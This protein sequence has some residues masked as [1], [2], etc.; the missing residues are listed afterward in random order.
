[1]ISDLAALVSGG[2]KM[3]HDDL[4]LNV[5]PGTAESVC[6]QCLKRIP[7]SKI[8]VGEKVYLE[9][10]CP[11]HGE[12][13]CL[14]WN[15]PP[16][17]EAWARKGEPVFP[18]KPGTPANQGCP[19]DCGLC[20]EHRQRTCCVLL[21]ITQRCDL[22]CPVCFA[23][24]E[25][26]AEA[27]PSLET[28]AGWYDFLLEQ[29]GPFNIQLSGGE[30][31]QRDDLADIIRMGK[32]KGFPFIQ[33]NT[34]G[35]RLAAEEDLAAKLAAAGLDC[36]FLQFDGVSDAPYPAL[37]GKP[38]LRQKLKAI[39]HCAKAGLGVVLVPTLA[40]GIND[41]EI[42]GIL[43]FALDR[44]PA[45]RGVHFQPMSY[46]GRYPDS[47]H[48]R[49]T[50]PDV[51]R[52]IEA[53]TGGRMKIQDFQPGSA[54]NAYCSFNGRFVLL[55]DGQIQPLRKQQ[56]GKGSSQPDEPLPGGG[57][58]EQSRA[59]VA[60]QWKGRPDTA[61][62]GESE[63]SDPAVPYSLDGFLQR[64]ANYTLAVSCM[65]FQDAWNL[66]LDRLRQCYIHTVGRD[67]RL[68][69]FCAYNLTSANGNTLYRP[70]HR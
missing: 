36:V 33:L 52:A 50:L 49:L 25:R 37:R 4:Q 68:I 15:G 21:E 10:S 55:E 59:F 35:L 63:T 23:S 40:K 26:Q 31:A 43:Q 51:L 47:I 39:E 6:P 28:I 2:A 8:K 53:Q 46:F 70:I 45:V 38:L 66:E 61:C 20:P 16:A 13:R 58:S 18:A 17:Y 67:L 22:A 9:K 41:Q 32:A 34:N 65:A 19:Y 54:E 64:L 69:P 11:E 5:L 48:E 1:M 3:S 30:P 42:G 62:C 56:A 57:S 60:R 7:G 27:D 44:L 12:F 24:A 29:G 14:I